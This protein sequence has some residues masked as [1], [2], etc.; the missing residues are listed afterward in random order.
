MS[1]RIAYHGLN[2]TNSGFRDRV[3]LRFYDNAYYYTMRGPTAGRIY[4]S[5][6]NG[7]S[8]GLEE[9]LSSPANVVHW[10]S[11]RLRARGPVQ[12]RATS[13]SGQPFDLCL[14]DVPSGACAMP[15][16]TLTPA[17]TPTP[18]TVGD[19]QWGEAVG[20]VP[21]VAYQ[22]AEIK[23]VACK[24]S[25]VT[26]SK[27][28]AEQMGLYLSPNWSGPL[29]CNRCG[30]GY[31]SYCGTDSLDNAAVSAKLRATGIA[32]RPSVTWQNS[33]GARIEMISPG[34]GYHVVRDF[35]D[36]SSPDDGE[37]AERYVHRVIDGRKEMLG[38]P[39]I[40]AGLAP[41]PGWNHVWIRPLGQRGTCPWQ[42]QGP[43]DEP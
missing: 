29:A 20:G 2:S 6:N 11:L 23:R 18:C 42:G 39:D 35:G 21:G 8:G 13:G 10:P 34:Q 4:C 9:W 30:S 33:L 32:S 26:L 27:A 3:H 15:T 28:A 22:C 19:T 43:C 25:A 5:S 41:F 24:Y 14:N 37:S 36:N 1:V 38:D 40:P 16:S 17:A 7:C 31:T 12:T